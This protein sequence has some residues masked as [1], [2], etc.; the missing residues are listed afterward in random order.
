MEFLEVYY[1]DAVKP[2]WVF[3]S[4]CRPLESI[5][6]PNSGILSMCLHGKSSQLDLICQ[7]GI[8]TVWRIAEANSNRSLPQ[9]GNRRVFNA[10][11]A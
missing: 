7:S 6:E 1:A 11:G 5:L 8:F 10:G 3:V 9:L 4:V 2:S